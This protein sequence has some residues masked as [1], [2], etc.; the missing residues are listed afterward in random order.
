MD[1]TSAPPILSKILLVPY[2]IS[3]A[4][5]R[6]K[7]NYI[8]IL[9]YQHMQSILSVDDL[10]DFLACNACTDF[11][12]H[13]TGSDGVTEVLIEWERT[14]TFSPSLKNFLIN[15]ALHMAGPLSR[16]LTRLQLS[17]K[18]GIGAVG[19]PTAAP[20][21]KITIGLDRNIYV[22]LE[23]GFATASATPAFLALFYT[24]I[25]KAL[26][27]VQPVHTVSAYYSVFRKYIER[28]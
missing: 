25:V 5:S 10:A 4:V 18:D 23:H 8:D 11:S 28:L 12:V 21:Y 7:L 17:E 1:S 15:S 16:V 20:F 9:N 26:Y 24:D 14:P 13:S 27:E 2:W 22:I 6:N 3:R 19:L